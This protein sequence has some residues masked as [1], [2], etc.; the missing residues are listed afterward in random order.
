MDRCRHAAS[1]PFFLG[2][3]VGDE[4]KADQRQRRKRKEWNGINIDIIIIIINNNIYPWAR[5]KASVSCL[6]GGPAVWVVWA[7]F[8]C[9]S[10]SS[11]SIC[12]AF[13]PW[14]AV[15]VA[16]AVDRQGMVNDDTYACLFGFAF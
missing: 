13:C 7:V 1:F 10:T 11:P 4:S 16:V 5:K 9:C 15:A 2:F 6:V 14:C 12:L 3:R 8:F